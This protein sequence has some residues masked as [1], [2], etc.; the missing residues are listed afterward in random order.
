[1]AF[2]PSAFSPGSRRREVRMSS[3]QSSVLFVCLGN[4]CRSPTAEAMFKTV[5]DRDGKAAAYEIDSCGTGG[6][7]PDW[8]TDGGWSYHEGDSSDSRMM[9]TAAKRGIALTSRSRPLN[10][11]DLEKFDRII[12]MDS[13][14]YKEIMK[15]AEY[16]GPEYLDLA[17]KK[18]SLMLD[19]SSNNK[20]KPVPDPYYGGSDGF[21]KVLDLLDEACDGLLNDMEAA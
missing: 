20:G 2:V 6:G 10:K 5:V 21:E 8:F 17:K 12:G 18:T 9:Q 15:A 7:N 11:E 3:S 19:Y 16:W 14:N 4:I 13:S 1:M